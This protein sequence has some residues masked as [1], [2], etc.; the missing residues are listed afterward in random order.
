LLSRTAPR[1]VPRRVA[2][3]GIGIP[4]AFAAAFIVGLGVAPGTGTAAA[5]E[6]PV[7]VR[8]V[9]RTG[10]EERPFG[11]EPESVK[12]SAGTT[13]RWV[14]TTEVFH[15]VTF[16]DSAKQ[17]VSNGT[18]D[19]SL[20]AAGATVERTFTGPGTYAYFCQPHSAFMFATIIVTEAPS[21][22]D[23]PLLGLLAVAVFGALAAGLWL[24][25]LST[26]PDRE[27]PP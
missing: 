10:D 1:A 9:P 2:A 16:S 23:I 6:A 12:I 14:N 22:P 3:L 17:R 18:F 20:F 21:G 26:P 8:L 13:V 7:E 15:T 24:R 27:T 19:E 11:F 25:R 5:Q 4:L